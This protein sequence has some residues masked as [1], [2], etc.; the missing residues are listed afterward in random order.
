MTVQVLML[1]PAPGSKMHED[2]FSG[3]AYERVDGHRV[4]PH[5]ID[6][7]HVVAS[8]SPRPYEKQ[9]NVLLAY[10]FFYNPLRFAKALVFPKNRRGHVADA[11][12]QLLGMAGWW[13]NV[14]RT[15]PWLLHLLRGRIERFEAP[16]T[17]PIPFRAVAGGRAPHGLANQRTRRE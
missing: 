11:G 2:M 1:S 4:E 6:G 3:L 13:S 15:T 14:V 16:P 8:R 12:L 17:S 9:L 5:L 7:N 10:L